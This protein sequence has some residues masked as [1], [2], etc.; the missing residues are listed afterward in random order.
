MTNALFICEVCG[1][2][3]PDTCP[4]CPDRG[5]GRGVTVH[6]IKKA[7]IASPTVADVNDTARHFG[8]HVKTLEDWG[9]DAR[10][11]AIQIKNLASYRRWQLGCRP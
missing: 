1:K 7:L 11:M 5:S 8:Q 2:V 4:T 9:Q 10:T 3:Y 6:Q